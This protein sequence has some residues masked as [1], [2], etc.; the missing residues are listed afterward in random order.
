MRRLAD[1]ARKVVVLDHH[2]TARENLEN[3]LEWGVI[4][5]EFDM[6][7]S[8]AI[9]AWKYFHPSKPVPELLKYVQDRDLW[10]FDL[11]HSEEINMAIKSYQ[12]DFSVWESLITQVSIQ[13]LINEGKALLRYFNRQVDL[14]VDSSWVIDIGRYKVPCVNAPKE[15]ASKA[16]HILAESAAFAVVFYE[17]EDSVVYS[18]RSIEGGVDV[19]EIAKANGGGGHKHAAGYRISKT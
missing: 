15:F 7:R 10:L 1:A 6:K 12:K 18:L 9:M 16:G 3:L 2:K 11:P 17:D 5:G 4:D 14:L 8:G 19:S 13:I